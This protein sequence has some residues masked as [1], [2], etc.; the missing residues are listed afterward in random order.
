MKLIKALAASAFSAALFAP[1]AFANTDPTKV[2]IPVNHTVS[3]SCNITQN[4]TLVPPSYSNEVISASITGVGLTYNNDNTTI[5]YSARAVTQPAGSFVM[6][7][8]GTT[9]EGVYSTGSGNSAAASMPFDGNDQTLWV[10]W[11]GANKAGAY[12]AI[13]VATCV[14]T[15]SNNGGGG[16]GGNPN[17]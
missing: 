5:E 10:K 13:V 4:P 12:S 8:G 14:E 2:E 15:P 1:A 16:G 7:A 11:T 6:K 17:N 3:Y 9:A